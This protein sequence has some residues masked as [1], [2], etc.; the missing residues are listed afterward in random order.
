MRN[1]HGIKDASDCYRT[2]GGEHYVA[3]L[4]FPSDAR[5]ASYRK[6]GLKCRRLGV[7]LFLRATDQDAAHEIDKK[8]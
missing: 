7:E 5:I 4:S 6:A 1:R 3:W 8:S 2:F